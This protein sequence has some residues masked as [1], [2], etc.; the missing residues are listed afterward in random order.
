MIDYYFEA[1]IN[2]RLYILMLWVPLMILCL[3]RDLN[4]LVPFSVLANLFIVASFSITL[5]YMFDGIPDPSHRR[6]VADFDKMPLFFST[7]I[8]AMEGIGVVS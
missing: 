2:I 8:F 1:G 3:V 6:L 5:Y 4:Y 7:V